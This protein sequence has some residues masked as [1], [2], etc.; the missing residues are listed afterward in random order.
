MHIYSS[1]LLGSLLVTGLGLKVPTFE[2]YAQNVQ[3]SN[4]VQPQLIASENSQETDCPKEEKSP[5]PGCG[6]RDG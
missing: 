6:R 4:S 2:G 1:I 3:R 5:L